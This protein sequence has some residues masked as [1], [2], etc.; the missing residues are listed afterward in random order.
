MN[1]PPQRAVYRARGRSEGASRLLD[2]G[3]AT[4]ALRVDYVM[5]AES[6]AG[7][8]WRLAEAGLVPGEVSSVCEALDAAPSA[9]AV[10]LARAGVLASEGAVLVHAGSSARS[11][12]FSMLRGRVRRLG[13][14]RE[15][16]GRLVFVAF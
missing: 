3:V 5:S 7:A 11:S 16:G 15:Q 1:G 4:N 9:L 12:V 6:A 10:A 8:A 13:E 2:F 14:V